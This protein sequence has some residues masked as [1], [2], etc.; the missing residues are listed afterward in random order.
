[1][2]CYITD[3]RDKSLYLTPFRLVSVGGIS[4]IDQKRVYSPYFRIVYYLEV[5]MLAILDPGGGGY[6]NYFVPNEVQLGLQLDDTNFRPV[7]L[8]RFV[9]H[10]TVQFN[11]VLHISYCIPNFTMLG[12]VELIEDF[13]KGQG[14]LSMFGLK[15]IG[16]NT[17]I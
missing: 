13:L 2:L 16:E 10:N 3:L 1:M 17:C 11:Q 14:K 5:T 12:K 4:L 9:D 8:L 15:C 7:L 6:L